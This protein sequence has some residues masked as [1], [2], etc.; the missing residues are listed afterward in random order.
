LASDC[1]FE[2]LSVHGILEHH[3]PTAEERQSFGSLRKT[4]DR[5]NN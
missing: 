2:A 1:R 5:S 4:F 3:L